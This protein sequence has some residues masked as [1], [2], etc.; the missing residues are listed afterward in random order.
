MS[1]STI[2]QHVGMISCPLGLNNTVDS[3]IFTRILFSPI[4]LKDILGM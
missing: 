2:L 1:Q 4:A 3:E